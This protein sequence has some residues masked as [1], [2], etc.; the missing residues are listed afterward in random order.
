LRRPRPPAPALSPARALALSLALALL[1]QTA[2]AGDLTARVSTPAPD[3]TLELTLETERAPLAEPDLSRIEQDFEILARR[4]RH[5]S[6]MVNGRRSD[7][8]SLILTLRP[9]R[10]GVTEIPPV[11]YGDETTQPLPLATAAAPPATIPEHAEAPVRA[12]TQ[13]ANGQAPAADAS[14][15]TME[16]EIAPNEVRV[17][18]QAILTVRAM[19]PLSV[20]GTMARPRLYEP[21]I[22]GASLL[23]LGEDDY[24]ITRSG[25]P[26]GVYERRYAVFPTQTGTLAIE[27]V[28][29]DAWVGGPDLTAPSQQ[30]AS[31]APLQLRVEAAPSPQA[32]QTWLP[33]RALTLTEEQAGLARVR[34]GETWQRIITL[35][36]EGQPASALP[37]LT[38]P[39]PQQ[40]A[41]RNGIPSLRNE[42][43]PDGVVGTRREFILFSGNEPGLY[44]LPEVRVDWWN[45][46]KGAWEAAVLPA[47]DLEV[48]A[49]AAPVLP[50]A[51][52]AQ[53]VQP[54]AQA[55]S[56][57]DQAQAPAQV[58][59]RNSGSPW[60]WALIA[61]G[62]GWFAQHT[63]RRRRPAAKPTP[64]AT[65][66]AEPEP[67]PRPNP[68]ADATA[69]VREAYQADNPD[70]ARRALLAWAGAAWPHNPPGNLTQLALRCPEPTRGRLILLDQTFFSPDPLNWSREPLW[71][72]LPPIAAAAA[73]EPPP[74]PPKRRLGT[75]RPRPS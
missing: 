67:L 69:A 54:L 1:A 29:A 75:P 24:E 73:L 64:D 19:A 66:T 28:V 46:A 2:G 13:P 45:I 70:A 52:S 4:N 30:R 57:P 14:A 20:A 44:R 18:Q 17:Q 25:E 74:P 26:Q 65:K 34:P 55:G 68:T 63:W 50:Q 37:Q 61:I 32:G 49:P 62:L 15:L 48:V 41:A 8:H 31:S 10:E 59:E 5:Q 58:V 53:P 16:T 33:A 9:H 3:G 72:D 39:A 36:A 12:S 21:K 27:P 38:A 51:Q 22:A 35:R 11:E 42:R 43:Q 6:F 7:S 56:A 23:P 60:I 71:E 47:R 40:I